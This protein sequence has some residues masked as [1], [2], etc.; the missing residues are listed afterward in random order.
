MKLHLFFFCYLAIFST[1]W[2]YGEVKPNGLFTRG[3]VLQQGMEIP[4]WG[5]AK[6]GESITV[7]LDGQAVG[8]VCKGG[9]WM[10]RLKPHAPGGPYTL[11]FKGENT[12]T[13][14]NIMVGEVWVCSGQ[15]NM[16]WALG[17]IPNIAEEISKANYPK[18]RMMTIP[19]NS[20]I[21]PEEDVK[22]VWEECSPQTAPHFSAVG[23]F[24]GRDLYKAKGVPVGLI[25]SSVGGTP[26]Q[27]WTSLSGLESEKELASYVATIKRL[28]ASYPKDSEAYSKEMD[29]Y[30]A[31]LN[32]WKQRRSAYN[33]AIEKWTL[34]N[35][36][37]VASGNPPPAKPQAM[38]APPRAPLCKW[39]SAPTVLYNGMVAPLQ[40]YAIRGVIWYQGESN[41]YNPT[42][43]GVLFPRLI[44]DWRE[45]WSQGSFPFLFVQI[46]PFKEIPPELREAQLLTWKKTPDTAMVVTIDIG[47]ADNIHPKQK[48]PVGE[49]L[50]LAARALAY[51][52]KIEYSGPVFDSM[53]IESDKAVIRFTHVGRGLLAKGGELKG[54]TI[55]GPDKIFLP[56]KAE[57]R[58][59]QI[60]VYNEAVTHPKSV[61]Y[62]WENVPDGNLFN[63]EGLPASPFRSEVE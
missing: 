25:N 21:L 28:M 16:W 4:I 53:K 1:S 33:E 34:E 19:Q 56:A 35:R 38:E 57:I 50:A 3:A 52:E 15:S 14:K 27:L 10:I 12:I 46:A 59:E 36:K 44:K 54:F 20:A 13:I 58:G 2:L 6:E 60:I 61:R 43:Y 49:R 17:R 51:G 55:A 42:E 41:K 7:A 23:Y 32:D 62:G 47:E 18:L 31:K 37:A 8:T 9:K 24:F 39:H 5:R 48:E 30:N 22:G 63:K 29:G 45:K 26:A 11:T 40:P